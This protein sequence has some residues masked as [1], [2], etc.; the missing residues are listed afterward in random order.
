MIMSKKQRKINL[1]PRKKLN[2]NIHVLDIQR[3]VTKCL[4]TPV[5]GFI[6]GLDG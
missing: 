5:R 4:S 1:E 6:L 2:H 3:V